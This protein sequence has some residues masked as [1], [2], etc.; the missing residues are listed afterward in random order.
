MWGLSGNQ[1]T[2]Q[3]MTILWNLKEFQ[4][5]SASLVTVRL[6]FGCFNYNH[7]LLVFKVAKKLYSMR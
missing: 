4:P 6:L 3:V 7:R 1:Q 5:C 2:G